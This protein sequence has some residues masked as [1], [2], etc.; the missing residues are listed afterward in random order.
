[1]LRHVLERPRR[2]LLQAVHVPLLARGRARALELLGEKDLAAV[3][4]EVDETVDR[5]AALEL[6][7][8]ASSRSSTAGRSAGAAAASSPA[9]ARISSR[10]FCG[11]LMSSRAER[12]SSV[13]NSSGRRTY[14]CF[15]RGGPCGEQA[16]S[17]SG[18]LR[19]AMS[20]PGGASLAWCERGLG[21]RGALRDSE[22][23]PAVE[24]CSIQGRRVLWG[25][26][27]VAAAG[28]QAAGVSPLMEASLPHW[29]GTAAGTDRRLRKQ[30]FRDAGGSDPR[31]A[32]P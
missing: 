18:W 4:A 7:R 12:A 19:R 17:C 1:V 23:V 28:G 27:G 13:L 24:R 5:D 22:K 20:R 31:S 6:G 26:E 32:D 8:R 14:K 25:G 11:S 15:Y 9:S 21:G 30:E 16:K 10:T 29:E 2:T 3:G